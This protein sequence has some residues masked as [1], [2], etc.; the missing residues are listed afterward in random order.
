MSGKEMEISNEVI[1]GAPVEPLVRRLIEELGTERGTLVTYEQMERVTGL[2]RRTARFGR[3]KAKWI[4]R[5]QSVGVN[6]VVRNQPNIG[7]EILDHT[8]A[9]LAVNTKLR[10]NNKNSIAIG[11]MANGIDPDKIDGKVAQEA[12]VRLKATAAMLAM[13]AAE[14]LASTRLLGGAIKKKDSAQ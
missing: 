11:V 10:R 12:A 9:V 13:Q 3:V 5:I 1:R 7:Y 2:R 6:V 8:E 14:A 4:K